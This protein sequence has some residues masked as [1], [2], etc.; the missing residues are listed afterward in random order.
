MTEEDGALH[1]PGCLA[2]SRV[3]G[4]RFIHLTP[5]ANPNRDRPV[6]PKLVVVPHELTGISHGSPVLRVL[7]RTQRP[8]AGRRPG[9]CA[10]RST[11][12][13]FSPAPPKTSGLY[14]SIDGANAS[15]I[16]GQRGAAQP[17]A[18]APTSRL[19]WVAIVPDSIM[20][21]SRSPARVAHLDESPRLQAN[22]G[23]R[24]PPAADAAPRR[25]VR[26]VPG[27]RLPPCWRVLRSPRRNR[28]S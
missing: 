25:L 23:R 26:R 11:P 15:L 17:G 20:S 1:A 13:T 5:V 3:G 7:G 24:A 10:C 28:G 14:F 12:G 6:A 8:L 21:S 22:S 19:T 9:A 2:S 4:K 16:T 18:I 27:G